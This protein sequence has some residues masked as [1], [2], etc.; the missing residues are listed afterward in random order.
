M[1]CSTTEVNS[2]WCATALIQPTFLPYMCWNSD[3]IFKIFG[4]IGI[5]AVR[6]LYFGSPIDF[7]HVSYIHWWSLFAI[8]VQATYWQLN[9]I[10]DG[11]V[12]LDSWRYW[13]MSNHYFFG[14]TLCSCA[15][16]CP[17]RILL[18]CPYITC[19]RTLG[20]N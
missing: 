17:I 15:P 2:I 16:C 1:G 11:V 8:L 3:S 5:V 7:F 6:F 9:Y 13:L 18:R 4:L 10:D 12:D 14:Q 20:A 19:G